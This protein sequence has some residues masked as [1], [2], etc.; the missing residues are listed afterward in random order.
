MKEMSLSFMLKEVGS[1]FNNSNTFFFFF[2][3]EIDFKFAEKL[4]SLEV[5]FAPWYLFYLR[6][7]QLSTP[8]RGQRDNAV[9][10]LLYFRFTESR[11][12]KI[13]GFQD[14]IKK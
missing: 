5:N 2:L 7:T 8:G 4:E 6:C 11:W 13:L 9:T 3:I 14:I 1:S 10:N 12:E